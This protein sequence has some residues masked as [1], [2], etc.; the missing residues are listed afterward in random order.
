LRA[1]VFLSAIVIVVAFY[2]ATVLLAIGFYAVLPAAWTGQRLGLVV[3]SLP[4]VVAALAVNT[5]LV[6][7]RQTTW[8]EVGWPGVGNGGRA[9]LRGIAVGVVMAGCTV[10]IAVTIGG[11]RLVSTGESWSAYALAAAS[12]AL[13]LAVAALAE[14][15]LFRGFPLAR[16]ASVLT[17]PGASCLLALLF[18]AAH[19]GNP[20][21]STSGLANIGLAA[22]VLSAAFFLPGGLPFAWGVH[23]GW[24]GG[25]A[26]GADAPV[27]GLRF[28]IPLVEFETGSR[29]WITGGAF[30]PEGGVAA[31]AVMILALLW[32]GRRVDTVGKGEPT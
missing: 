8:R 11:A 13:G 28:D 21:V 29:P 15:L 18:V 17:R 23:W 14:E 10:G 30:G 4:V 6:W 12:L 20:D 9:L 31:T 32:F 5:L 22:L 3:M 26:L 2:A 25:L 27:S 1:R 16:L 7:R 19:L 24:N